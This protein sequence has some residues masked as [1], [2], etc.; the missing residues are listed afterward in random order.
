M[1]NR[2]RRLT[3]V[4]A[5]CALALSVLPGA[6]ADNVDRDIDRSR[7]A[8]KQ[9]AQSIGQIEASLAGRT[10]VVIKAAE[11]QRAQ[12]NLED[13]VN[14]AMDAQ[15]VANS[16]RAEADAARGELG[17]ISSAMYRDSSTTLTAANALLGA[18]SLRR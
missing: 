9:T 16:A 13:S 5:A 7:A 2:S 15:V 8:E 4:L 11:A 17:S 6:R 18:Q 10:D 12:R 1:E 14:T 3:A